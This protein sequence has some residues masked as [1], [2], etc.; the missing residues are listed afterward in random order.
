MA[1][2]IAT[3]AVTGRIYMGRVN[4]AGNS[5]VGQKTDVTSDVMKAVIDKAEYH[6]DGGFEIVSGDQRWTVNVT[7][8]PHDNR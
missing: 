8:E 4:K 7:K 1:N 5:F 2:R 6:G 3:A